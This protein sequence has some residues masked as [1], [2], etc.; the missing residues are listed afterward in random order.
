MLLAERRA[1]RVLRAAAGRATSAL[2]DAADAHGHIPALLHQVRRV[3]ASLQSSLEQAIHTARGDARRVALGRLDAELRHVEREL[4]AEGHPIAIRRPPLSDA[5]EDGARAQASAAS[6]AAAWAQA[7]TAALLAWADDEQG[8]LTHRVRAAGQSQEYRIA[9]T[10]TT[11]VATAYNDEHDEGVGYVV[12]KNAGA[13]WL[14]ALFHRWDATLDRMTCPACRDHDG[15]I[16]LAGTDFDAGDEPADVHTSCRC[17]DALLFL[18]AR[19]PSAG[20]GGHYADA[21]DD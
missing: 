12:E 10:A 4:A 9:R 18:P 7:V 19:L 13:R 17:H 6:Y 1:L 5:A 11:E 16:A 8:K 15:E 20:A 2:V 14:A 3:A 21:G